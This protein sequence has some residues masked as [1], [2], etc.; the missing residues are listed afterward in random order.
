MERGY[1]MLTHLVPRDFPLKTPS[2][3]LLLAQAD[4]RRRDERT[5]LD[6]QMLAKI[7][8]AVFTAVLGLIWSRIAT[9]TTTPAIATVVSILGIFA[10]PAEEP[11]K[12][13]STD[14]QIAAMY[15]WTKPKAKYERP[16]NKYTGLK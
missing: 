1:A 11:A 12:T 3:P 7:E 4:Y 15:T 10:L 8:L 6:P 13:I 9:S 5:T 2:A 14:E 16:A